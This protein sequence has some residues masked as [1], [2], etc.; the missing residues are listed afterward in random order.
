M[1][2]QVYR[3]AVID[4]IAANDLATVYRAWSTAASALSDL[5]PKLIAQI[6]A[7]GF[8]GAMTQLHRQHADAFSPSEVILGSIGEAILTNVHGKAVANPFRTL[9]VGSSGARAFAALL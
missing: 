1:V 4:D 2:Y 7:L 3:P 8:D 9:D 6:A 5:M